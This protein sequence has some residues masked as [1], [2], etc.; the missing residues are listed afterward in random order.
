MSGARQLNLKSTARF[1]S[2]A[3]T[4]PPASI[5]IPCPCLCCITEPGT[6]TATSSGVLTL[7]MESPMHGHT[8]KRLQ[9]DSR[10]KHRVQHTRRVSGARKQFCSGSEVQCIVPQGGGVDTALRAHHAHL[11]SDHPCGTATLCPSGLSTPLLSLLSSDISA[12]H[13]PSDHTE[14]QQLATERQ[15][16]YLDIPELEVSAMRTPGWPPVVEL[17]Q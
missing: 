4:R 2:D 12:C 11:C 16:P 5:S 9:Q 7:S 15:A 1:Y 8:S 17:S 13:Q 14:R 6:S 10:A 3:V